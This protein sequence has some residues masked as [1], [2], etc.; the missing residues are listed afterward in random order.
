MATINIDIT[1]LAGENFEDLF[2]KAGNDKGL[3]DSLI[4]ENPTTLND[5]SGFNTQIIGNLKT[6]SPLYPVAKT[7]TFTFRYNRV[8]PFP[9][10]LDSEI[11]VFDVAPTVEELEL[12][13]RRYPMI[14]SNVTIVVGTIPSKTT[15]AVT[16]EITIMS[17]VSSL[18]YAS[19]SVITYRI[20]AEEEPPVE[21]LELTGFTNNALFVRK[22]INGFTNDDYMAPDT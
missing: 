6:D 4:F 10:N 8:L 13:V 2:L 17:N 1:K 9:S 11:A 21:G 16:G 3:Y 14:F 15:E 22:D 12:T 5:G 7:K 19:T 18:V 20:T